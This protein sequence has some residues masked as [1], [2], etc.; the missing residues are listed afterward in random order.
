MRTWQASDASPATP[1]SRSPVV[2]LHKTPSK[3]RAPGRE[4]FSLSVAEAIEGANGHGR[5]A[6]FVRS[7]HGDYAE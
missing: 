6:S 2:G 1:A 4:F 7:A 5:A 3:N